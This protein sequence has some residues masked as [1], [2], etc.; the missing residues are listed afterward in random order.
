MNFTRL[1]GLMEPG[2]ITP[3]RGSVLEIEEAQPRTSA[4]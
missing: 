1:D 2:G 3:E 4:A